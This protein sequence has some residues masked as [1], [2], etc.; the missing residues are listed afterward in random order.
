[1]AYFNGYGSISVE[2]QEKVATITVQ[3]P[4]K[5][6]ALS[7]EVYHDLSRAFS[8]LQLHREVELVVITGEGDKAFCSGADIE[9]Y[10]GPTENH[11]PKQRIR[12]EL[13]FEGV[14]KEVRNL[15]APT[16]AKINGY[17]VGGG[18]ILASYCDIRI[19]VRD[20][21]FGVP[22]TDI[23]QIP[24]GGSTYRVAQLIG[25]AKT[26][27]LVFTANLI[28]AEEAH[29]IGFINSIVDR[30][31]LDSTVDKIADD[32]R[33]TG[34]TAVKNSKKA[35]N[36]SVEASDLETAH[37]HERELWWEQFATEEREELV[38]EFLND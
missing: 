2:L 4:E 28:D 9:Q 32:V 16:V 1:M 29:Q 3:R 30:D 5:Y 6:N 8:E 10:A 20:A 31:E 23:G 17:C 11:D 15:H 18:F 14:Y 26:K 21:K 33:G 24:S 35:I 12:R 34:R 27:E 38:G 37:N 7:S 19:A 36:Y 25:E 13:F 22:V